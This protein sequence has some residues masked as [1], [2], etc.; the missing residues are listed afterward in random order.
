MRVGRI[1]EVEDFPEAIKPSYKL[2]IDFGPDIGVKTSSAQI[3]SYTKD[4]LLG[5]LVI[6]VVNFPR[7]QITNFLSEVLT[8]GVADCP[9]KNSWFLIQPDRE[10]EL[11]AR[12]E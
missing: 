3:R 9:R 5:R 11:G 10:V 7:K 2:K 6:S 4:E 12:V 8:L 1:V